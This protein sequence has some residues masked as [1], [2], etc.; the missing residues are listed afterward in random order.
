MPRLDENR[1]RLAS[2][3]LLVLAIAAT[4]FGVV[5]VATGG[6]STRVYG[7]RVSAHGALRPILFAV[8]CA[9]L[10]F[11][12]RPAAQQDALIA[13][14]SRL[15]D[16]L[17][18]AVMP[19]SAAVV[20]GLGLWYGARSAGGSDPYGYIS[21]AQLWRA[22]DLRVHQ[23]F[24]A[25][26]PW[27]NAD[28]SFTPL[29]Y[30]PSTDHTLVPTYAPGLPL[31]MTLFTAVAGSCGPYLVNPVCGA[32]LVVLAYGIG[33]R[34]SGRAVGA[35]AALLVASSPTVLF[36]MLWPMSD[37]P[38]AAFW[39][40]SLL[41][42]CR[43]SIA[44]VALSGAAAGIAIAIRPNL[45]PLALFPALI[46][47]WPALRKY[48]QGPALELKYAQG[49]VFRTARWAALLR[50]TAF[51]L[52][53]LPFVLLVAWF[54][55]NLYGSPF[56]SG[57]GSTDSIFSSANL[58]ANLARY[59][60]W[61]WDTQGP[62]VFL[63]VLSPFLLPGPT[64]DSRWLRRILLAFA[65]GVLASY[66][67]YLPFDAWW[68][69]RFLLP[70]FPVLFVLTAD[71]VWHGSRRFGVRTQIA[72]AIA[73]TVIM[74]NYAA[75]RASELDVLG[76]GAGEQKYADVGRYLAAKLPADAVVIAMQHSGSIRHY[77]GRPTLRY[78]SLDPDWLDRAIA[79][80][81]SAG[82]E[83]YLLLE[84]FELPLFRER[85]AGQK[86]VAIVDAPPVALHV[87]SDVR[88]YRTDGV[89][90]PETP[91]PIPLTAGCR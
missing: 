5:L 62:L 84:T 67:W 90:P 88:L 29:G 3:V 81:R 44:A 6:F 60:R 21:Q 20:L 25:S 79:H 71:V 46:A 68:F 80:L 61:L 4:F 78:D 48:A 65:G 77:S 9:A 50:L 45:V 58:R 33:V 38:A 49:A 59:P 23:D 74:V 10:S 63:F 7:I 11:R 89:S 42:A 75:T 54:Y 15:A 43:S 72:A 47:A 8:L 91:D 18:P 27:P 28:W 64:A 82:Q 14:G 16:R 52:A 41:L 86:S 83:P 26:V 19:V 39:T 76:I 22:G 24:V 35:I 70:A 30:R 57:Y 34:V 12:L 13:R 53:C 55:N 2:R 73:F 85:F 31:L 37:V 36:M 17:L 51:G 66:L 56:Q 1:R 69:L 40:A 32:L 87:R